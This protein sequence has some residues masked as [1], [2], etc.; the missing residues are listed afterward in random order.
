MFKLSLRAQP[1]FLEWDSQVKK[2]PEQINLE[3]LFK[4]SQFS[5]LP[6]ME[7]LLVLAGSAAR[8]GGLQGL[9]EQRLGLEGHLAH[10]SGHLPGL[11]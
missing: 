5:A 7:Q 3:Q 6:G 1:S 4:T 8:P 10:L 2:Y 11:C 9:A